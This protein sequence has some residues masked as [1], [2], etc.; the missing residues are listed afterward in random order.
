MFA[1]DVTP[2][3]FAGFINCS[4]EAI[5]KDHQNPHDD[6]AIGIWG[7]L[8]IITAD[9]SPHIVQDHKVNKMYILSLAPLHLD[10]VEG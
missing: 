2:W 4:L 10:L 6:A 8:E 9:T 1:W 5:K 3:F 7:S